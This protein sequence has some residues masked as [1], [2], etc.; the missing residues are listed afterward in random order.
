MSVAIDW[1]VRS[2][3]GN[4]QTVLGSTSSIPCRSFIRAQRHLGIGDEG[5]LVGESERLVRGGPCG[6][7]GCGGRAD[8]EKLAGFREGG[9][10]AR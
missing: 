4:C 9:R 7:D 6:G 3:G 10:G 1:I 8:V 2:Y 5:G